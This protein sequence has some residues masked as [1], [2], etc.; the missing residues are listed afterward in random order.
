[1]SASKVQINSYM[2]LDS[3]FG[4]HVPKKEELEKEITRKE[5]LLKKT[6][7]IKN[8]SIVR[9]YENFIFT[10][11]F[12][13]DNLDNFKEA[14]MVI[15]S[16]TKTTIDV[17]PFSLAG[18]LFNREDKLQKIVKDNLKHKH[19][20]PLLF[21]ESK[22]T[23]IV[24]LPKEIASCSNVSYQLSKD[25][26]NIFISSSLENLMHN[27]QCLNTQIIFKQ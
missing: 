6:K 21:K 15:T 10:V 18:N 26:K 19:K 4:T 2:K 11:K 24:H 8:A 20:H 27:P 7:G 14:Y 3:V 25:K 1:M 5:A 12:D 9:D 17:F 13:F 22:Y 16:D 23:G